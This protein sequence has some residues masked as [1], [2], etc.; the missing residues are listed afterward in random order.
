MKRS[1]LLPIAYLVLALVSTHPLWQRLGDSLPGDIGDPVLN[2]YIIAWDT[3]ALVADPLNLFNANIFYPLPNTLAY[4][5]NL[6][7]NALLAL[8]IALL[9]GQPVLAYNFIFLLSFVL[10]GFAMYL[11]TLRC[12][13]HRYAAFVA[14]VA[15]AFAPYRLAS[16]AHIQLLTVQWLPFIALCL[17]PCLKSHRSRHTRFAL[18]LVFLW[19]QITASLHGALFAALLVFADLII[20]LFR[21][22]GPS[23]FTLHASR[24]SRIALALFLIALLPIAWPYLAVVNELRAARPPEIAASFAAMPSDFLAAYPWNRLF[25]AA[26]TMFRTRDGSFMRVEYPAPLKVSLRKDKIAAA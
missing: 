17:A 13:R 5:E 20:R 2:T 4:S 19:L 25:G 6:M 9:T 23:R 14:G 12:T 16:L 21:R 15:F 8:P 10:A 22:T 3:H 24:I 11:F 18:L 26:T 1:V 7:G